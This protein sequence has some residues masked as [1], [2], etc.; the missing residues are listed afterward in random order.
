MRSFIIIHHRLQTKKKAAAIRADLTI[1]LALPRGSSYLSL[2]FVYQISVTMSTGINQIGT[3]FISRRRPQNL[4]PNKSRRFTLR[5]SCHSSI[6]RC[7]RHPSEILIAASSSAAKNS[8][9]SI[10]CLVKF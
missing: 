1:T 6:R 3:Y 5:W 8:Q 10:I 7:S 9:L 2:P 4:S